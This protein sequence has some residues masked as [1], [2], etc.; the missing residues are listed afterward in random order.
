MLFVETVG[1]ILKFILAKMH[2]HQLVFFVYE[3][4]KCGS[5]MNRLIL[6][7]IH[8]PSAHFV[9]WL[10]LLKLLD[11]LLHLFIKI[12]VVLFE[13]NY[14]LRWTYILLINS[15]LLLWKSLIIKFLSEL[16]INL[17]NVPI[18]SVNVVKKVTPIELLFE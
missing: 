5:E 7:F 11:N 2:V 15:S 9:L 18:V 8:L 1:W 13:K 10:L 4:I 14:L 3:R 17:I 12:L 16:T 6:Y